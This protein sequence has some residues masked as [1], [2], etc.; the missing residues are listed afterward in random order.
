[1]PRQFGPERIWNKTGYRLRINGWFGRLGNNVLQLC[2]AL[3]IAEQTKSSL[4]Y[5]PY[6]RSV[7]KSSAIDFRRKDSCGEEVK[8]SF[9]AALSLGNLKEF[10]TESE[11]I[12]I[13][14]KYVLPLMSFPQLQIKS[15]E[16]NFNTTLVIHMRSGDVMKLRPHVRYPQPPLSCYTKIINENGPFS[17]VLIVTERDLKNPCVKGLQSYCRSNKI[18]C[19]IQ[20]SLAMNDAQTITNARYFVTSQSSF[21]WAFIR[22]N[23]KI[24]TVFVPNIREPKSPI[25]PE[26]PNLDHKRI[27]YGL[28]GYI[29]IGNW[30]NNEKQR[31][32]M[33]GYPANR[34]VVK[35][36]EAS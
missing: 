23:S 10:Y 19:F 15:P 30:K 6:K 8:D 31:K 20:S 36:V 11:K 9:F 24:K 29:T 27:Y 1:M 7:I 25:L 13:S 5:P 32:L 14:R 21:S 3:W 2:Q 17:H 12:R 33:L 26:E 4:T 16:K 28:P 22:M 35:T 34:I 18:S